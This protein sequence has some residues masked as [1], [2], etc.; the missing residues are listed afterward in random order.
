MG[1]AS[2]ETRAAFGP[3]RR[4]A[5]CLTRETRAAPG[6]EPNQGRG[7]KMENGMVMDRKGFATYRE[8]KAFALSLPGAVRVAKTT[9]GY[10]T[11]DE[12]GSELSKIGKE[13]R[14]WI[15][16]YPVVTPPE[17]GNPGEASPEPRRCS[18]PRPGARR[19]EPDSGD[20]PGVCLA[21][22]G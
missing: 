4:V 22:G 14:K 19:G 12:A 1:L 21:P 7:G 11:M 5:P 8:A 18:P 20:R 16:N 10:A 6:N 3:G 17:S 9:G 15:A 2:P 13:G